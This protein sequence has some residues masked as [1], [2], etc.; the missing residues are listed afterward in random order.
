MSPTS[1]LR[2]EKAAMESKRKYV[3]G[4]HSA[5]Q[6][7]EGSLFQLLAANHGLREGDRYATAKHV[8]RSMI[9][10]ELST[11][12]QT[13]KPQRHPCV[14]VLFPVND[15]RCT[16]SNRPAAFH[17]KSHFSSSDGNSPVR[18]HSC[19]R[20][21]HSSRLATSCSLRRWDIT[22]ATCRR[23]ATASEYA[24]R[25]QYPSCLPA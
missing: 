24:S 6:V 12:P 8:Q 2:L 15:T 21:I 7:F 19:L 5:G 18:N 1:L 22:W 14:A 11:E 17:V 16:R 25:Y 13:S 3:P 20:I 4:V 23:I 9:L 10:Q